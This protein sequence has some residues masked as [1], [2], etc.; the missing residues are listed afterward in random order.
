ML[1]L[2]VQINQFSYWWSIFEL[3][4]YRKLKNVYEFLCTDRF[5]LFNVLRNDWRKEYSTDM[6]PENIVGY[7]YSCTQKNKLAVTVLTDFQQKHSLQWEPNNTLH[8]SDSAHT[9]T[10]KAFLSTS[11]S[12]LSTLVLADAEYLLVTPEAALLWC[13]MCRK[14]I[15]STHTICF[16]SSYLHSFTALYFYCKAEKML[17]W[18]TS[19]TLYNT[20]LFPQHGSANT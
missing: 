2:Y 17:K 9:S 20:S 8:R 18:H 13:S 4:I 6:S 11:S 3:W 16:R 14:R 7:W 5:G 15:S 1:W 19:A 12:F 10:N